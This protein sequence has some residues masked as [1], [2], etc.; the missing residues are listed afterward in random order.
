MLAM[1]DIVADWLL[2]LDGCEVSA[3]DLRTMKALSEFMY[4]FEVLT[5]GNA[6]RILDAA[7]E[8]RKQKHY[9][10][11]RQSSR[12]LK[13]PRHT[14]TDVDVAEVRGVPLAHR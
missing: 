9:K 5:R 8:A 11:K 3:P 2:V 7:S 10:I 1:P 6:D 12:R 14:E 13:G 4:C